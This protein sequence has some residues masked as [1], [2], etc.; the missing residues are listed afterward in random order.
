MPGACPFQAA[1]NVLLFRKHATS[2]PAEFAGEIDNVSRNRARTQVRPQ[3]RKLHICG[4]GTSSA[5]WP[6]CRPCSDRVP[7]LGV[8]LP[9]AQDKGGP[10]KGGFLNNRLFSYM[11]VYLCNELSGMC[12]KIT[13]D[14]GQSSIIQETTFTRTTFVLARFPNNIPRT[15]KPRSG[16]I[17]SN[18]SSATTCYCT[19]SPT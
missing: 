10:S 14:L 13:Y 15:R 19:R 11:D 7:H 16:P 5:F 17:K 1:P 8:W 4:S 12:M 6:L 9:L 2:V 18:R 3:A